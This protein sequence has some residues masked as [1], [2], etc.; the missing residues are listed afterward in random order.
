MDSC[1]KWR[2]HT[3]GREVRSELKEQ[4]MSVDEG[5][6]RKTIK[7]E[8]EEMYVRSDQ[9]SMEEGDMMRTIKEEEEETYV[10]IDQHYTEEKDMKGT[11]KEEETYV[12]S[13]RQ[14]ME[15]GDIMRT[16]KVEEEMYVRSYQQSMEEGD[17][18]GTIKE[19][20]E[21]TYVRSDK[22]SMEECD[23]MRKNKEEE[24]ETYVRSD[25]QSMEECDMMRK[26]KEE[27]PLSKSRRDNLPREQGWDHEFTAQFIERYRRQPCLWK[28]TS[29]DYKDRIKRGKAYTSLVSFCKSRNR[30]VDINFVKR[31]IQ[32]LRTVFHKAYKTYK[33][34]KKSGAG[35]GNI[36]K[37]DLWYYD[38]L[39]FVHDHDCA[40]T[41]T[42]HV[43][44]GTVETDQE[45]ETP[46][47]ITDAPPHSPCE[48]SRSSFE[49]ET[50]SSRPGTPDPII[51][52]TQTKETPHNAP[53][54]H[55]P[56][57]LTLQA[58]PRMTR[59]LGSGYR[60]RKSKSLSVNVM[61]QVHEAAAFLRNPRDVNELIGL[62]WAERMKTLSREQWHHAHVA[63]DEI[64]YK[65]SE[66]LLTRNWVDVIRAPVP[67]PP[68]TSHSGP[69]C[70]GGH[71]AYQVPLRQYYPYQGAELSSQTSYTTI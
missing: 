32:N 48:A 30:E 55:G 12:R 18:M 9:L 28:T 57:S 27:D 67:A 23:M 38:L 36:K 62:Q 53:I 40:V 35:A 14:S 70:Q 6:M 64:L 15:E 37:P 34:S 56:N 41:T 42:S 44:D 69:Q 8:E 58:T 59:R 22:Q 33:K 60:A 17:M 39:L 68:H 4:E 66:G 13:D 46:L 31:K 19:E 61:D 45:V 11:I 43:Q 24:E 25:Q 5:D 29:K 47:Q 49:K 26:N 7:E 1:R 51:H 10:R 54:N 16:I 50:C 20:E 71:M 3:A 21:E 63:I 52:V 2:E 65:A